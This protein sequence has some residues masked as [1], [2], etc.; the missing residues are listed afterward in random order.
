MRLGTLLLGTTACAVALAPAIAAAEG[1]GRRIATVAETEPAELYDVVTS[2]ANDEGLLLGRQVLPA[3][4]LAAAGDGTGAATAASRT[5]YLNKNGVTLTPGVNDARIN[6]STVVTQQVAIAPWNVS[7]ATWTSTVNCIREVFAPF[8]VNIVETDP[9]NVPHIEAVFGGTPTQLGL[10]SNLAGVSPFTADCA[11]IEN[12]MVFAFT[13]SGAIST[14]S[15]LACEVMAQEIAHSYGL[16]HTLQSADIMTY[17]PHDG[18]RWF[19]N[20]NASCGEDKARP[21]GLNGSTCRAAQNSVAVLTE[22]VGLKGQAGDV[23]APAVSI[24]SPA[25]GATV[26]PSFAV[27][28][29]ASDNIRVLMTSLYIDG[30]PSGSVV[31]A[32]LSLP[33]LSD[34]TEGTHKLRVVATDGLNERAQEITVTVRKGAAAPE[35]DVMGG[36][37]AGSGGASAG[38]GAGLML[39]LGALVRRRRRR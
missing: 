27:N 21:C 22:R 18:R 15:K 38:A 24:T 39:A 3:A 35:T 20:T 17:L 19:Q 30:A 28:F 6:R 23:V 26:P 25:N 1:P 33:M 13:G 10:A 4:G 16:D 31:M 8:N 32:P 5:I 14:D 11:V 9:G 37:S 7:A 2:P 34:L 29:T 36:C 12:S